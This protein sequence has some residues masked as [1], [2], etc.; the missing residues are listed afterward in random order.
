MKIA[1]EAKYKYLG[2][3]SITGYHKLG[4][5]NSDDF[6]CVRECKWVSLDGKTVIYYHRDGSSDLS[7]ST[8]RAI[9]NS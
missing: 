4:Y 5:R 7:Y 1:R 9:A 6:E 8:M 2:F 3:D